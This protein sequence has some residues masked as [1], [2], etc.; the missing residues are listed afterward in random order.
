MEKGICGSC[1]TRVRS[2]SAFCF[3]CG[4]AVAAE[5]P[6]PAIVKP[7]P[8]ELTGRRSENE[9][10]HEPEPPPVSPPLERL[11][12]LSAPPG[13]N[14]AEKP[15]GGPGNTQSLKTAAAVRRQ[16]RTRV[17]KPAEVEWIE[18]PPSIAGFLITAIVMAAI[19]AGLVAAAFY[20]R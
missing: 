6:P 5:P 9:L 17:K 2:G 4:E 11:E 8:R 16:A 20:L 1:G 12:H 10:P 7:D 18:R 3:S 13:E 19:A 15:A 14:V